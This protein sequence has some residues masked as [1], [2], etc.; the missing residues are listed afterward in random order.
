[1][2]GLGRFDRSGACDSTVSSLLKDLGFLLD[3]VEDLSGS[4]CWYIEDQV[5]LSVIDREV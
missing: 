5:V 4:I 1:M 2:R 3:R